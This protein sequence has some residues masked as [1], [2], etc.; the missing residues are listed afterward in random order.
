M[1][2]A[3]AQSGPGVHGIQPAKPI[4]MSNVLPYQ[5]ESFQNYEQII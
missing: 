4:K 3:A 5:T 2:C 1:A